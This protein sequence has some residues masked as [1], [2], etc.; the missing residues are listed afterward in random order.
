MQAEGIRAWLD[1][2]EASIARMEAQC[3][4]LVDGTLAL[5]YQRGLLDGA[6]AASVI[7]VVLYLVFIKGNR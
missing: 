5:T 1:R 3:Q 6:L 4:P 7:L 2:I